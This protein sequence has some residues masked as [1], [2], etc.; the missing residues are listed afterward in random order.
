MV[1]SCCCYSFEMTTYNPTE[2]A[3]VPPSL[4]GPLNTGANPMKFYLD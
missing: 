3:T 4:P 1:A 2:L